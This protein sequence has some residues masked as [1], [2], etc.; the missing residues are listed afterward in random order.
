MCNIPPQLPLRAETIHN[1]VFLSLCLTNFAVKKMV[2]NKHVII[3]LLSRLPLC[4]EDSSGWKQ[5]HKKEKDETMTR[6]SR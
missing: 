2:F 4:Q 3:A 1:F 6:T 5:R